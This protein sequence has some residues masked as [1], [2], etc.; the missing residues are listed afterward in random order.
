M[1]RIKHLAALALVLAALAAQATEGPFQPTDESL[2]QYQCPE[3]F[4][5]AKFGIWS[6][7]GPQCVPENSGWYAREMY[8]E[9]SPAYKFHIKRYGHPSVFGFKDVI[10]LWKAEKFDPEY[11][12]DLYRLAGAKYF[13]SMAAHHDNFDLW[14]SR[15]H[16]WN[17]TNYGPKKNILGLWRDAAL[18]RGLRFG[19]SEHSGRSY[20]WFNTSHGADK[21]GP[22]A[23]VPYDGNNPEFAGLYFEP[24]AD[25]RVSYPPNAPAVVQLDWFYRMKD[26]IDRY[27]PDLIYS[28]GGIP[29]GQVGRDFLANYYNTNLR[30]NDGRLEAVYTIKK[31]WDHGEF[32]EGAAVEDLERTRLHEISNAPWQTDT[33][34][35]PWFY[36]GGVDYK[37]HVSTTI[38]L[39]VDI[40]SK[41]G[42]LLLNIPQR[43][44][45]TLEPT[46]EQM[47]RDIGAWMASNGEG[48]YATR[49][50][51][52]FGEGGQL[53]VKDPK[54]DPVNGTADSG[55]PCYT[56]SDF[57]FT[58]SKDGGTVYAFCLGNPAGEV[59]IASLG[60]AAKLAGAPVADVK[61]LGCDAGVEWRQESEALVVKLPPGL[62]ASPAT[63][64]RVAFANVRRENLAHAET[65]AS[66]WEK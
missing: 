38:R 17:S 31:V 6:H 16:A 48:I 49:P 41:N 44:D 27:Q 5:D 62:P 24:H 36:H 33:S 11:L 56:A 2:K 59:R 4:R 55:R 26:V 10:Q 43:A 3:W 65:Q 58:S 29:H 35:G 60:S 22:M 50:W 20:S 30:Q 21:T 12:M 63:G 25:A 42:N 1:K 15:Y 46:A 32:L 23:G 28:D 52:V 39:L 9:G 54:L 8:E 53:V 57:R 18:R 7:W 40:V 64:F 45:G 51:K 19:V 13:V 37:S 47:L 61:I 14:D 66:W 34:T